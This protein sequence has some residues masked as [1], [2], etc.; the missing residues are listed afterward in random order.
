MLLLH[1]DSEKD[2]DMIDKLVQQGKHMFVIVYMVG[3]GPCN[4]TRPEWSKM[5]NALSKRYKY[6]NDLVIAD[7]NK[8]F[9]HLI[10]HIGN[11]DGFPTMKYISENGQ[12]IQLYEDS[13]IKTK[14]R[15]VDSF[16][17]WVESNILEGKV[18][19]AGP[20]STPQNVYD[21]LS[22]KSKRHGKSHN[23]S[24]NKSKRHNKTHSKGKK[25]NHVKSKRHNKSKRIKTR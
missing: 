5:G 10:K 2:A 19:S 22:R 8:D 11:I 4:A 20:V 9:M 23:K 13:N 6:D 17:N 21:R 14:D 1:I 24:H 7:V 25:E 12:H 16:I 18:V 3:C 15:S